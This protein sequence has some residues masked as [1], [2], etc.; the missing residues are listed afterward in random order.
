[1]P[2]LETIL[3][4]LTYWKEHRYWAAEVISNEV[5]SDVKNVY[6]CIPAARKQSRLARGSFLLTTWFTKR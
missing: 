2:S 3:L 5:P 4:G 1:M 6:S